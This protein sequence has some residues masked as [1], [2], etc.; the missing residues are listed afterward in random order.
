MKQF[1]YAKATKII[2]A[3]LFAAIL[4]GI[5]G[6]IFYGIFQ[7]NGENIVYHLEQS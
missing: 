2:A 1:L 5:T 6:L 4:S 7:L 3:V